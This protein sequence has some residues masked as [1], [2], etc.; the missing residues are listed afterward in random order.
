VIY[1]RLF[2]QSEEEQ[3]ETLI[4][5]LGHVFGL[6]HFFALVRESAWPAQVFG[7]HAPFTIMNYGSES[8]LTDADLTDLAHLYE[9]TWSGRL[10]AVNGTRVRL[11]RPFNASGVSPE[12]VVAVGSLHVK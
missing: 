8:K 12:E 6:R 3:V 11:V 1:P 5:E 10:T 9:E 7:T 4:H 2:A